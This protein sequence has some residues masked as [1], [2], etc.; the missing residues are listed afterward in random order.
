MHEP[1]DPPPPRISGIEQYPWRPAAVW[2][3]YVEG[4]ATPL[5]LDHVFILSGE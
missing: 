1:V 5:K 3:V 2:P 4:T